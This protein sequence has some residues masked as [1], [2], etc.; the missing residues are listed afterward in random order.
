[1]LLRQKMILGFLVATGFGALTLGPASAQNASQ[2]MNDCLLIDDMT[3]D[4][5]DC[6]DAIIRP[7]PKAKATK[8]KN[9]SECRFLKEEDE[10]LTCFNGFVASR[11]P[12][13]KS[14][15]S[16]AAPKTSPQ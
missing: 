14:T 6:F 7:A 4:R 3:K 16:K 12:P 10:R 15:K 8:A 11:K 9:V 1:M 13:P 2:K 5:L